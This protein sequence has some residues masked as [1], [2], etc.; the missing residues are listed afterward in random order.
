MWKCK[1]YIYVYVYIYINI[2]D[3]WDERKAMKNWTS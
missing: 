1:W 3:L 2:A